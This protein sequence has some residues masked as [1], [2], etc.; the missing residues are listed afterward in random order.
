[1]QI[2]KAVLFFNLTKLQN[3]N[4]TKTNN[5]RDIFT[6]AGLE[7]SSSYLGCVHEAQ[8]ESRARILWSWRLNRLQRSCFFYC[9]FWPCSWLEKDDYLEN[10]RPAL[11][12]LI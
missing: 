4:I 6:A 11:Y 2:F 7:N 12:C 9:L 10:L 1:M 3:F 5:E 8:L